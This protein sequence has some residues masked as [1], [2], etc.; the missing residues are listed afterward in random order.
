MVLFLSLLLIKVT[1]VLIANT[2]PRKYGQ[3]GVNSPVWHFYWNRIGLRVVVFRFQVND[4]PLPHYSH[5]QVGLLAGLHCA[6][7]Q[8]NF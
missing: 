8:N 2:T 3:S 5:H 1:S 7:F 6:A 4:D